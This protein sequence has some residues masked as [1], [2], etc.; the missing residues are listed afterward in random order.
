MTVERGR[1]GGDFTDSGALVSRGPMSSRR[2][3]S[4][5]EAPR[6]VVQKHWARTLHYDFRLEIAGRLVSWAVPKGPS[7]DP[8]VKRLA[9]RMPDHPR[10][11]SLFEGVIPAGEYGAGVVMI[12]DTGRYDALLPAKVS[13]EQWLDRGY[14]K[15]LLHGTKLH[16]LWELVRY[17]APGA[18][19]ENWLWVKIRDRYAQP[20]YDPEGQPNSAFSG[21][22]AEELGQPGIVGASSVQARPLEAWGT[23]CAEAAFES[24]E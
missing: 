5:A 10:D 11:Y 24:T 6:F 15:F 14:L 7:M 3:E 22:T 2:K 18:R 4:S 21:K 17:R 12:W 13:P 23:V 9:V 20:G 19:G 16:G 1:S 8:G